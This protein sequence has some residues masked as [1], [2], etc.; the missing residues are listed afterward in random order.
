MSLRS[1]AGST[2]DEANVIVL[3]RLPWVLRDGSLEIHTL[4]GVHVVEVRRHWAIGVFLDHEV[5]VTF[6]V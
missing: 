2:S 1:D 5:N 6:G 4:L 3:V